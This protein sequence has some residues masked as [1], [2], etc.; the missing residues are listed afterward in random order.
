MAKNSPAKLTTL[1]KKPAKKSAKKTAKKPAKK[2]AAKAA[3][4]KPAKKPATKATKP[5]GSA[6]WRLATLNHM[7]ALILEADPA[8][9][10]E[11]KWKKPSNGM[12][13][14]PVFSRDGIICTGETY[15][16]AVKLTFAKGAFV[17]DPSRLFNASLEGNLRRAI[18][19]PEGA[20][21]DAAAFK[22]LVRAA[23]ALNQL[24][25]A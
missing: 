24:K 18:D 17:P 4:K 13:G 12:V 10:E 22:T 2:P 21:V 5:A 9:V 8:I 6:D 1:K 7:R 14:V 25:K 16:K 15:A 11:R 23:V 3:L 20:T 19:I